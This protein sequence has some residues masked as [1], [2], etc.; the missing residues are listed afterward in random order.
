MEGRDGN[1][2]TPVVSKVGES[3]SV[4]WEPGGRAE[5]GRVHSQT[6]SVSGSVAWVVV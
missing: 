2:M 3:V 4:G 6:R 1:D 5:L